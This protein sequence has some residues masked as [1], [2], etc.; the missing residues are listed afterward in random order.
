[1]SEPKLSKIEYRVVP[2]TRYQVTRY[3]EQT[4]EN[5][6]MVGAGSE[7][8]GE[9]DNAEQA[10]HVGYALAKMEHEQQGWPVGDMRIQYP[11]RDMPQTGR[12]PD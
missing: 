4:D 3:H 1:M 7:Q 9:F 8:R 12:S 5:G 11:I 6:K 10:Y 2:V